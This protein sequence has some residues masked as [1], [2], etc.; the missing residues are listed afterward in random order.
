MKLVSCTSLSRHY[1]LTQP[2]VLKHRCDHIAYES[3]SLT[4]TN[5]HEWYRSAIPVNTTHKDIRRR[6]TANRYSRRSVSRRTATYV[7]TILTRHNKPPPNYTNNR[8][9][10]AILTRKVEHRI[11]QQQRAPATSVVTNLQPA[12]T[13]NGRKL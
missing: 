1:S 4:M 9:F 6:F 2:A 11:L 10:R 5:V 3:S 7:S 8:C 12:G 13:N